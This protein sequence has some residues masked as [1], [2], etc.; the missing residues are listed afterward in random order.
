MA[1]F[2]PRDAWRSRQVNES[3]KRSLVYNVR[4]GFQDMHLQVPCGKCTGCRAD[5]ALMW[6]IRAYH[7][8]TLHT[9]NSFVTLTYDE[10][11]LPVDAKLDKAHLQLFFKR[12][13]R[14]G[15][16]VRY[17]A[18][19]EY[20]EQ[21]RRPH[22]HAI[23]FGQDFL[24]DAIRIN[25]QLYSSPFLAERWGL[26]FVSVAPVNMQSICYV[27]GYTQ[28]KAGDPDTFTLMSRRPGIGHDWLDKY[29][30]DLLHEGVVT[31]EGREYPVP[32]RYLEWYE[33]DFRTVKRLRLARARAS[34]A[35][36]PLQRYNDLKNRAI[37][38][39]AKL[40]QGRSEKL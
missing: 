18:C 4:E 31:I 10:K 2:Y 5:Q 32:K 19:G 37:N 20:G 38:H 33:D 30:V 21:S 40:K 7:E 27:C 26:G 36:D 34:V 15:N 35:G 9:Q 11:H 25:D 6:S 29:K 28:K 16:R 17:F 8:S 14:S 3:G 39:R 12:F 1:C 23:I 13:R 22:Y 24:G